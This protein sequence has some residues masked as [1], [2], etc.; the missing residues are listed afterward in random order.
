QRH[1]TANGATADEV[2]PLLIHSADWGGKRVDRRGSV[3]MN[4]D[5][6]L[7]PGGLLGAFADQHDFGRLNNDGEV[8][9]HRK[10]LDIE[11]VIF[12][13]GPGLL[14][15]GAVNI[16]NLRPAGEAGTDAMAL[17][18][19]GNF[20]IEHFAEVRHFRPG[21]DQAHLTTQNIDELRQFVEPEL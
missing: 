20:A 11:E 13:L 16:A 5:E 2:R 9:E 21:T 12:E 1:F 7:P 18:E 10:M 6:C 8:K 4:G 14:E 15:A 17:V 19:E 3:G